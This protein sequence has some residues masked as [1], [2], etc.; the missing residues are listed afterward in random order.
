RRSVLV[1]LLERLRREPARPA[2]PGWQLTALV[3]AVCFIPLGLFMMSSAVTAWGGALIL[4]ILLAALPAALFVQY[5]RNQQRQDAA[6]LARTVAEEFPEEV[7]SWGGPYVLRNPH[8]VREILQSL[9]PEDDA[10][11]PAFPVAAPERDRRAD[12][13]ARLR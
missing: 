13:L 2:R 4:L 11:K 12:L 1:A 9:S 6:G 5:A 3:G 10:E 7:R 8:M